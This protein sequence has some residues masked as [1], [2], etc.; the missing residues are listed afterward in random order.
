[1]KPS[2]SS[3]SIARGLAFFWLALIAGTLVQLSFPD[4]RDELPAWARFCFAPAG[5]VAGLMSSQMPFPDTAAPFA[6]ASGFQV[7][8]VGLTLDLFASLGLFRFTRAGQGNRFDSSGLG[9]W[10]AVAGLV[11]VGATVLSTLEVGAEAGTGENL[12]E[13]AFARKLGER[14]ERIGELFEEI[15]SRDGPTSPLVVVVGDSMAGAGLYSHRKLESLIRLEIGT[16][17]QVFRLVLGGWDLLELEP[18]LERF[19]ALGPS[20][21]LLQANMLFYKNRDRVVLSRRS[22]VSHLASRISESIGELANRWG[23][24][25]PTSSVGAP[26]GL[27]MSFSGAESREAKAKWASA[28]RRWAGRKI[29]RDD[30]NF[31]FA[32]QFVERGRRE[33]GETLLLQMPV[34]KLIADS[35]A[36]FLDQREV[37]LQKL[38]SEWKVPLLK[39]ETVWPSPVFFDAVHLN[40]QG[41]E[42]L[43][44]WMIPEVGVEIEEKPEFQSDDQVAVVSPERKKEVLEQLE[45]FTALTLLQRRKLLRDVTTW[46]L[47]EALP[48]LEAEAEREIDDGLRPWIELAVKRL[49][50]P[51]QLPRDLGAER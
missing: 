24:E 51:K 10:K 45:S 49:K 31:Q 14:R 27:D 47:V 43:V 38:R 29:T 20:L 48:L 39:T 13:A 5:E 15:E 1:M 32:R 44:E 3:K 26:A 8:I 9:T 18:F 35:A 11:F 34:S 25:T 40:A 37:F 50:K 22:R 12:G 42:R 23:V 46:N 2:R 17:V 4:S 19:W 41:R 16:D 28:G 30:P 7:V 36:S 6:L 33:G 21:I